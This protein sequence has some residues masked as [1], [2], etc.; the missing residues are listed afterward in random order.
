MLLTENCVLEKEK[1]KVPRKVAAAGGSEIAALKYARSIGSSASNISEL[2]LNDWLEYGKTLDI[3]NQGNNI[4]IEH[5]YEDG[6][7]DFEEETT[8]ENTTTTQ[9]VNVLTS[10]LYPNPANH[11]ITWIR[12]TGNLTDYEYA[13]IRNGHLPLSQYTWYEHESKANQ[14]GGNLA[15]IHSLE[16]QEFL[17]LTGNANGGGNYSAIIGIVPA[18][19]WKNGQTWIGSSHEQWS[20]G[21][22]FDYRNYKSGE[23]NNGYTSTEYI[24]WNHNY[25][26][27]GHWADEGSYS[28]ESKHQNAIYKRP[29]HTQHTVTAA[30]TNVG[31]G[32]I[33]ISGDNLISINDSSGIVVNNLTITP[34]GSFD[35]CGGNFTISV[36]ELSKLDGISDNIQSQINTA[37]ASG[38]WDQGVGKVY[39]NSGNVGIGTDN[40]TSKFE[41][42]DGS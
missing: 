34:E 41:V 24:Y 23:P 33:D 7:S 11:N 5:I 3:D 4:N 16:E 13:F 28:S 39:Y 36:N 22:T 19:T 35:I 42:N 20:D 14:L 18:H 37:I 9:T 29:Y 2:K 27:N 10:S 30:A 12:G 21:T 6:D 8:A 26:N 15:S 40:P 1:T 25:L 31:S 32:S 38:V 17:V